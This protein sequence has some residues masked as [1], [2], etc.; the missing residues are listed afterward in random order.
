MSGARQQVA[1]VVIEPVEDLHIGPVSQPAVDEVRLPHLVGLGHLEAHIGRSRA[2]ARL[3]NDQPGLV[4]DPADRGGRR[5]SQAFALQMPGDRDRP[6]VQPLGAQ[7]LAQLDHPL[8][9]QHRCRRSIRFRAARARLERVQ[10]SFPIGDQKTMEMP[11]GEPVLGSSSG[12]RQLA[13]KGLENSNAST[14]HP[15]TISPPPDGRARRSPL[16]RRPPGSAGWDPCP[17]S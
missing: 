17:D 8:A 16:R 13:G 10:T 6:G 9:D 5:D 3:G 4:Q 11:A 1:G 2:L 12:N 15:R 7:R 14:R